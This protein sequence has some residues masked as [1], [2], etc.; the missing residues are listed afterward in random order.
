MGRLGHL[1][2]GVR[3]SDRGR[4]VA[5]RAIVGMLKVAAEMGLSDITAVCEVDNSASIATIE[6]AGGELLDRQGATVRYRISV[7]R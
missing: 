6:R 5:T 3:P 1:G 2:Y 7:A 4:G